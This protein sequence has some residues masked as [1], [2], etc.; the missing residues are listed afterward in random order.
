MA[1]LCHHSPLFTLYSSDQLIEEVGE[2]VYKVNFVVLPFAD[3]FHF[4][5]MGSLVNYL[6]SNIK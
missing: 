6:K 4:Y 3:K 5:S 1:T 2:G